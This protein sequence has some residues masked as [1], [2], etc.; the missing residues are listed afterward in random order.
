MYKIIADKAALNFSQ[1]P[2]LVS[3][4]AILSIKRRSI[5]RTNTTATAKQEM[6]VKWVKEV[7]VD[8]FT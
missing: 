5:R 8:L 1:L 3:S 7:G 2:S 6:G 4:F